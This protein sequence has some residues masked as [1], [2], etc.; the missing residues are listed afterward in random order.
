MSRHDNRLPPKAVDTDGDGVGRVSTNFSQARRAIGQHSVPTLDAQYRLGR[1]QLSQGIGLTAEGTRIEEEIARH[2][3]GTFA[4]VSSACQHKAVVCSRQQ[5]VSIIRA[6]PC[7]E[8]DL[9]AP[10]ELVVVDGGGR[11]GLRDFEQD[12]LGVSVGL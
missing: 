10:V 7:S 2:V 8:I 5:T 1:Q 6:G 12:A 11:S 3:V 4:A 9:F